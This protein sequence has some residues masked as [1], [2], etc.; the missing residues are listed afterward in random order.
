VEW[1]IRHP[2]DVNRMDRIEE[3]DI[4]LEVT[5]L[6]LTKAEVRDLPAVKVRAMEFQ[7]FLVDEFTDDMV[8]RCPRLQLRGTSLKLH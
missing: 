5:K 1:N 6:W 2:G 4:A 8:Y 7:K 3:R